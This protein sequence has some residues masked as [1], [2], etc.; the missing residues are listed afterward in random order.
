MLLLLLLLFRVSSHLD[1]LEEVRVGVGERLLEVAQQLLVPV[2][3]EPK[4]LIDQA[5]ESV[6]ERRM[7]LALPV[8]ER[9]DAK[10][11]LGGGRATR[12]GRRNSSSSSRERDV[13]VATRHVLGQL[14]PLVELLAA[15][16]KTIFEL[17]SEVSYS[18]SK[19][20]FVRA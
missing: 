1:P 3:L 20:M 8:H 2:D 10:E 18:G 19:M 12:C 7:H 9:G 16:L 17:S 6:E 15:A 11:R 5:L 4:E 14:T 13:D